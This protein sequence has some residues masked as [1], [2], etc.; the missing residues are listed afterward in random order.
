MCLARQCSLTRTR[1]VWLFFFFSV[2]LHSGDI[3]SFI[4]RVKAPDQVQASVTL[5]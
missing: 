4:Y 3:C 2:C 5:Y 1:G